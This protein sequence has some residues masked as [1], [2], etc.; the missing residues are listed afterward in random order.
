MDLDGGLHPTVLENGCLVVVQSAL[1]V[2]FTHS[3]ENGAL[4][5][6]G[7]QVVPVSTLQV[8]FEVTVSEQSTATHVV[9]VVLIF[10]KVL[11]TLEHP[12]LQQV[13]TC[14]FGYVLPSVLTQVCTLKRNPLLVLGV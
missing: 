10:E 14:L 13:D 4:V 5:L 2:V 9:V 3:F 1:R 6:H 8:L 12:G 11:V 7:P